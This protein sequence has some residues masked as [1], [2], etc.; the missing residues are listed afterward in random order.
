M[1]HAADAISRVAEDLESIDLDKV[2]EDLRNE[3]VFVYLEFYNVAK[4]TPR[5]KILFLQEHMALKGDSAFP[6]LLEILR[7]RGYEQL[8]SKLSQGR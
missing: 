7:K 2:L 5:E 3:G 6:T 4:R 1:S 8:V